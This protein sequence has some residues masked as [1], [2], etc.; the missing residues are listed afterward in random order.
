MRIEANR[1]DGAELRLPT[2]RS[3]SR[4]RE[5]P[6]RDAPRVGTKPLWRTK[7]ASVRIEANCG[8]GTNPFLGRI[9]ANRGDGT[10][11]ISPEIPTIP[12]DWRGNEPISWR[13]ASRGPAPRP[14]TRPG[15]RVAIELR[16]G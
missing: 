13:G 14:P 8:D 4:D 10:N 6:L 9:E 16:R 3:Q 15:S 2:D 7:R 11:P 1:G 5:S 12:D